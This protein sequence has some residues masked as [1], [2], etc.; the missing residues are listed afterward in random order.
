MVGEIHQVLIS[1]QYSAPCT[2]VTI[3][4]V[5]AVV[6]MP[7]TNIYTIEGLEEFSTYRIN[8]TII[9]SRGVGMDI[10]MADTRGTG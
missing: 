1:A 5:T 7:A 6:S 2:D 4:P 3:P 8:V 10:V 9:S